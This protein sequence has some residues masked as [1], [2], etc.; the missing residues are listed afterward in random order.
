MFRELDGT[1]I[2]IGAVNCQVCF[3]KNNHPSIIPA[4]THTIVCSV[5]DVA[6]LQEEFGLCRRQGITG[7]PRLMLYT[8]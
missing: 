1:G 6:D 8:G 5:I 3:K 2:M 7:Y 4:L